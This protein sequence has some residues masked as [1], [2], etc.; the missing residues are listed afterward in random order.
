MSSTGFQFPPKIGCPGPHRTVRNF[1][2]GQTML[3]GQRDTTGKKNPVR[4]AFY[5][6][7][8]WH[9]PGRPE[10]L[11]QLRREPHSRAYF[12]E[13]SLA[14][15]ALFNPAPRKEQIAAQGIQFGQD[16]TQF[17]L[18]CDC[19]PAARRQASAF[20]VLIGDATSRRPCQYEPGN[21]LRRFPLTTE[22]V[23]RLQWTWRIPPDPVAIPP[24]ST[25]VQRLD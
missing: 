16:M 9:R 4:C 14:F 15:Q 22:P 24:Q 17:A 7:H 10:P 21:A 20:S 12:S 19:F 3:L 6:K 13:A 5:P 18:Q 2:T 11:P 8:N 25:S 23:H 1:N